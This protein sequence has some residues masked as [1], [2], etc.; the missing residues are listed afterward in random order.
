MPARAADSR[1]T[2]PLPLPA[3]TTER[4]SDERRSAERDAAE[5]WSPEHRAVESARA[6]RH[7]SPEDPSQE[8]A[9]HRSRGRSSRRRAVWRP[10]ALALVLTLLGALAGF[11]WGSRHP[12]Q[13]Q[14]RSD[15]LVE[16]NVSLTGDLQSFQ[17]TDRDVTTQQTLVASPTVV[18]EASRRTGVDLSRAVSVS[19]APDSDILTL[20]AVQP[21]RE[22]AQR[23]TEAYV[24][25]YL[26]MVAARQKVQVEAQLKLA[27]DS[28]A[29][30]SQALDRLDGAVA[31]TSTAQQSILLTLQSSERSSLAQQQRDAQDKV[32]RLGD[33]ASRLPVNLQRVDPAPVLTPT[34]FTE[35]TWT[36]LGAAAGLVAAVLVLA[37]LA[38][39]RP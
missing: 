21:T 22:G 25:G 18:A 26:A 37:R 10:V 14:G 32:A 15:V 19:A 6:D 39:R 27:Q 28:D 33:A 34:G 11:L 17:V 12:V 23:A 1:T 20:Q 9:A 8:E 38:E 31:A 29:A 2:T 5:R 7:T 30:A 13:F 3:R 24:R 4:R 35:R 16:S 36:L